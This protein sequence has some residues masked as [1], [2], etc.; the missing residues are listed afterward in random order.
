VA[1]TRKLYSQ[2]RLYSC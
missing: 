1:L 2:T